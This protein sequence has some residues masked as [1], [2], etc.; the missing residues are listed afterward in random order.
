MKDYLRWL[1]PDAETEPPGQDLPDIFELGDHDPIQRYATLGIFLILATAALS[2]ARPIALPVTAGMVLGI[3]LGPVTDRLVRR[4]L[5]APL[6]AALVVL[7]MASALIGIVVVL[8]APLAMGIDQLPSIIATLRSK[9]DG[10][11]DLAAA[12]RGSQPG[13]SA[14][15]AQAAAAADPLAPLVTIAATSTSAA[16][17]MLIFVASFYFYLA[18]RRRL[19][20]SLLRMCLGRD[21]RQMA[22]TFLQELEARIAAYFGVVTVI[23]L[24]VGLFVTA[25]A[26]VAGLPYPPFWGA[27]AFILNFVP[28]V[29]PAI[30]TALIFGAGLVSDASLGQA[31]WPAAVYLALNV[32]EGNIVSPSLIGRRLTT[33]PFMVFL[34]FAFWL[35]LWGPVGA[36]LSTPLLLIAIVMGEVMS[37]YRALRAPDMDAPEHPPQP[38]LRPAA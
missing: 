15:A 27:L 13:A 1:A 36:I 2:I 25:L 34:S 28:F 10:L 12:V 21:V 7:T 11:F 18:G 33:S 6:A 17:G 35:W 3:V 16:G 8:A 29:G 32:V 9:L 30:A 20:A 31:V 37:S 38:S 14:P 23:N 4:G 26:W 5:P 24:L 19:K 22:D